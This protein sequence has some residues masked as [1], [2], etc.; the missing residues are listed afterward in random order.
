MICIYRKGEPSTLEKKISDQVF[1]FLR[2]AFG[3]QIM[4]RM[5]QV[6]LLV[7]VEPSFREMRLYVLTRLGV[8][9]KGCV[10]L[11]RGARAEIP[12]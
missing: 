11:V 10:S 4:F 2:E 8:S 9:F 3:L 6:F 1:S 12:V 7:L 5:K